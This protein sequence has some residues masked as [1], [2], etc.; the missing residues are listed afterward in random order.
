MA[1]PVVWLALR[2]PHAWSHAHNVLVYCCVLQDV[3]SFGIVLWEVLTWEVPFAT[4]NHWQVGRE[5]QQ[6]QQ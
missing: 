4:E 3:Y 2:T 6:W 1:A 5:N